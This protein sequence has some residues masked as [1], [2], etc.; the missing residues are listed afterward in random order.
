M[1]Y[2]VYSTCCVEGR[3]RGRKG[4]RERWNDCRN[5]KMN[6]GRKGG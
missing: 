4:E 2:T 1:T 5:V 3:E 6:V